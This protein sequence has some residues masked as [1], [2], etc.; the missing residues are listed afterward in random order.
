METYQRL[1]GK[2]ENEHS[3]PWFGT[4][5]DQPARN[6]N[7]SIDTERMDNI[8]FNIA[9]WVHGIEMLDK[10]LERYFLKFKKL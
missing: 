8:R 7:K 9:T 6:F 1:G 10:E 3:N 4:V 5:F 2:Y